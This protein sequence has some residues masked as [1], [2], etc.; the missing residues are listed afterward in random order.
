M[1]FHEFDDK[2]RLVIKKLYKSMCIKIKKANYTLAAE[3]RNGIPNL[4]QMA[5]SP[6]Y[7]NT[8]T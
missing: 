8:M 1:F 2:R 3:Y 7:G 5:I 6:E 4:L